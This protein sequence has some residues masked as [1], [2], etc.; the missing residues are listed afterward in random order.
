MAK[1]YLRGLIGL[2]LGL[3]L[4]LMPGIGMAATDY[5]TRP[6][7]FVIPFSAGGSIDLIARLLSQALTNEWHQQVLVENRAGADGDL[8]AAYVAHSAPDG[9]T[10]F[11]SSQAVATNVALHPVRPYDASKDIAPIMLI[12]S[13]ASVLIA[14]PS[15][16]AN[17]VADVVKAAKAQPGKLNYAS[18]GVGTSAYLAMELFKLQA[19]L[20]VLHVPYNEYGQQTSALLN[21]DIAMV[22]VTVPQAITLMANGKLKPLAVGGQR[23]SPA[24]P[25]IPTMQEAGVPGYEATTWYG[26]FAPGGTQKEIVDRIN[27]GFKTALESPEV[28]ARFVTLGVDTVASTPEYMRAYLD[29]EIVKWARVV[30]VSGMTVQ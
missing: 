14:S 6:V 12:A 11:A 3:N 7:H 1:K 16:Q 15:L 29:Q 18:Q 5:P 24:L 17:S 9:Y 13:T 20:D 10:I 19:G 2:M 22:S 8:G 30:K 4:W 25:D 23:R 28:K 27:A 21:G 26:L